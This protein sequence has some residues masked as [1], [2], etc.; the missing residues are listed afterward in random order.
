M[1]SI[2]LKV[3]IGSHGSYRLIAVLIYE[4]TLRPVWQSNMDVKDMGKNIPDGYIEHHLNAFKVYT[5][6]AFES[7]LNDR[8]IE[9]LPVK[10]DM[11]FNQFISKYIG[12]RVP[13]DVYA[14]T[15]FKL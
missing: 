12:D 9:T 5:K 7:Y 14:K 10:Y 13:I 11:A 2:L 3:G 15:F 8:N 1:Y 6:K 4:D